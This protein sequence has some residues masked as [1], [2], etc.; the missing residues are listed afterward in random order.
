VGNHE[1]TNAVGLDAQSVLPN[2]RVVDARN[3][4]ATLWL[5]NATVRTLGSPVP[6]ALEDLEDGPPLVVRVGV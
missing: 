2:V 5:V 1:R 6:E 3:C 4:P